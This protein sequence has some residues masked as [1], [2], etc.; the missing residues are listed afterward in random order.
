MRTVFSKQF[1][2][3]CIIGFTI[4]YG[5]CNNS[6]LAKKD[7]VKS[8]YKRLNLAVSY[9]PQVM[10]QNG[11][12][13]D[14]EFGYSTDPFTFSVNLSQHHK[15]VNV[16]YYSP[17]YIEMNVL[18]IEGIAKYYFRQSKYIDLYIGYGIGVKQFDFSIPERKWLPST[19]EGNL[20]YTLEDTESTIYVNRYTNQIHMGIRA[21]FGYHF[22]LESYIGFMNRTTYTPYNIQNSFWG[23]LGQ[24]IYPSLAFKVGYKF[25][26][27]K[28]EDDY[29]D[30]DEDY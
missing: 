10:L 8:T 20:V 13:V 7:S 3:L 18:G 26:H 17:E 2:L 25:N 23:P 24:G 14:F 16:S 19:F 11:H 9:V 21:N 6:F 1:L 28:L 5:W 22:F 15:D 12:R 30:F 4:Q 29:Y 27:P